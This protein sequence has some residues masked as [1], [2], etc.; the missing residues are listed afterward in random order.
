MILLNFK[1]RLQ[2]Y[3]LILLTLV[4]SLVFAYSSYVIPGGENVGIQLN[5]KYVSIVGFYKVNNRYIGEES[6]FKI[7]DAITKINDENVTNIEQMISLIDQVKDEKN[8]E[9]TVLRNGKNEKISLTLE[10]DNSGVYK[11][12]LYVKDQINGIGTLS[13]I[14]PNTSI[15]GALGHEIADKNT[16]QMVELKD[17]KIFESNVTEVTPSKDGT[18]GEKQAKLIMD[19]VYGD[20][21]KNKESG[22]FGTFT[23]EISEKYA[24][25]V[26][27]P[28]DVKKGKA[29]IRTVIKDHQVEDFEIEIL[30]IDLS[31]DT[32][33][34]LFQVTDQRLL[35]Q[36]GGI[37]AG[38]SGSPI[39]QDG[40]LIGAVTHVVVN[41]TDKGYGIFITT[42]LEEGEKR[43][44]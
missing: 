17:G 31:S 3:S 5:T 32:K 10:K 44:E 1:K 18:P 23:G 14:D 7:G 39:I 19:N 30:E 27:K 9:V 2:L 34:I 38:M 33:N 20:I 16:L 15:Y 22:I 37:V 26:G 24:I 8:I 6:G 29:S 25:E 13:Y 41:D 21:L 4:P 35:E 43:S 42:M 11:T 12:G 28:E 36:T 40:K